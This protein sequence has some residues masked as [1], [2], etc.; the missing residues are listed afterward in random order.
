M[1]TI[2]LLAAGLAL[3]TVGIA[4]AGPRLAIVSEGAITDRWAP[5][6]DQPTLVAGYPAGA[7]DKS[8]DVCVSI[9][10]MIGADG[11]TS[12][13][14]ELRSW[15]SADG[16]AVPD[17]AQLGPFV[18]NAAAVVSRWKYVPLGKA[19]PVY[20][21]ASFAF[22]GSKTQGEAAILAHCRIPDLA[23]FVKDAQGERDG[24]LKDQERRQREANQYRGN[25]GPQVQ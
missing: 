9:G 11:S 18:Q 8:R 22:D 24:I 16:D 17:A 21:A 4:S 14:S 5:A 20:T 10:Y 15:T 3:A 13:F 6:P 7:A 1:N 12:E 25:G 19:K 23:A 2:R